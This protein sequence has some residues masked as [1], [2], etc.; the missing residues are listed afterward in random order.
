MRA[1]WLSVFLLACGPSAASDAGTSDAAIFDAS[2]SFDAGIDAGFDAGIADAGVYA[3]EDAGSLIGLECTD[4]NQC[5]GAMFT[6]YAFGNGTAQYCVAPCT[7]GPTFVSN[8][9][10]Q[11]A[12]CPARAVC[13]PD[14]N[15]PTTGQCMDECL[16]DSD[17]RTDAG[18]FCRNSFF[19]NGASV[20]TA[21]G[22]CAP[23]HCRTRGCQSAY[24]CF[25]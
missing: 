11:R 17:C 23:A 7:P 2:V 24:Q 9:R 3:L 21:N 10:L 6:C 14:F 15:A 22:Y 13:L 16:V 20:Q 4:S 8:G 1:I 5:G 12:E 25:C 19:A 18:Y